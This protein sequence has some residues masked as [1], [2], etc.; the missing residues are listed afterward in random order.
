MKQGQVNKMLKFDKQGLANEILMKLEIE[1]QSALTAWK[2]E[3]IGFMNYNEFKKN[4]NL[5]YEIQQEGK[6][7]IAYLKANT[8][9]L[10]DSYGTGS[11]M[12]LDNPGYQEYRNNKGKEAGQ[13]N[14]LRTSNTIVGR[15]RGHY[16]DIFGRKHETSG[17]K[18]GDSLEGVT[19]REGY[20]IN[21]VAPSRA[22]EAGLG[23]LYRQHLPKAYELAIQKIDFSKYLIES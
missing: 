22:V 11:L 7:I 1:L 4:A 19:V 21:P 3:V 10:A 20:K 2:N 18:A 5:D 23:M 14:P 8:Y 6:T 9:V 13:W 15:E 12:L 16:T 17:S